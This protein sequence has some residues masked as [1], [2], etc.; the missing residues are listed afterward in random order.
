MA[1]D[2]KTLHGRLRFILPT[3]LGEV[4][5]VEGIEPAI[6]RDVLSRNR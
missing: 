4:E 5:L 1:R 6:I 2:K 3:R